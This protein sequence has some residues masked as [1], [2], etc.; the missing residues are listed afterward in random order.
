MSKTKEETV[1]Q[2]KDSLAE[3]AR[4]AVDALAACTPIDKPA[5]S[6]DDAIT[7]LEQ[8]LSRIR[9]LVRP[10]PAGEYHTPQEIID[11]VT[12]NP[13]IGELPP[14]ADGSES[15]SPADESHSLKIA[16]VP[17]RYVKCPGKYIAVAVDERHDYQLSVHR[18]MPG[19][20]VAEFLIDGESQFRMTGKNFEVGRRCAIGAARAYAKY[21]A[22]LAQSHKA[23]KERIRAEKAAAEEKGECDGTGS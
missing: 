6:T 17:A 11:F 4:T 14:G 22:H 5:P 23:R 2:W 15:E 1:Q 19:N 8:A 21:K 18:L 3:S 7:I 12:A 16:G 20:I 9:E 10:E 13:P